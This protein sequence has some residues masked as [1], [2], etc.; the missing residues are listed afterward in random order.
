MLQRNER[1][2]IW[3][4]AGVNPLW[5]LQR[6]DHDTRGVVG[7][8][9][10][11]LN[12]PHL[13]LVPSHWGASTILTM[14]YAPWQRSLTLKSIEESANMRASM[15]FACLAALDSDTDDPVAQLICLYRTDTDSL[16]GAPDRGG[17]CD[18]FSLPICLLNV[19]LYTVHPI[20]R[21]KCVLR[22]KGFM[23]RWKH[24]SND[25]RCSEHK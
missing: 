12:G 5:G 4:R 18:V 14:N 10:L 13:G 11:G 21:S 24:V 3:R 17:V 20:N 16:S 1:S 2:L 9:L 8:S 23:E 7:T 25:D 6:E 15:V 22:F 19:P